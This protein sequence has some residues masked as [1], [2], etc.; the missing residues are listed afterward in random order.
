MDDNI[1]SSPPQ[2]LASSQENAISNSHLSSPMAPPS[3]TYGRKLRKPPPITP[4]RFNKFFTPRN[5]LTG[6]V[7]SRST[8]R[9]GRQL[10]D[11]TQRA[12]N[13]RNS[14]R[15]SSTQS[16]TLFVDVEEKENTRTP[17]T[18]SARKRRK[19][20]DPESSP[21]QPSPS[22]K[23]RPRSSSAVSVLE[24]DID[25]MSDDE[26]PNPSVEEEYPQPIR[27]LKSSGTNSRILQRSFGGRLGIDRGMRVDH[28][29]DWSSQVSD[30]YTCPEDNH[31]FTHPALPFCTTSCNT[32]SL[33][34]IGDEEGGVRLVETARDGLS[35]FGKAHVSFRPHSNAVMDL[36]F[37][38]D[39]ILLATA[40]GDQTAHVI[41]MSTQKPIYLM[42]GHVSSVK[43]VLFQPG[44]DSIIA[45]SSRDGAVHLWDL[46][47]SGVE[48]PIR[49]WYHGPC[50]TELAD[51]K[52]TYANPV[53]SIIGAH[54]YRPPTLPQNNSQLRDAVSK[55]ET[56]SRVGDVSITA[57]SFLPSSRSHLLLTASE[58]S[59]TVKLWD[60]RARC[61]RRGQPIALST[62]RQPESH[63][64]HRHFGINSLTLS[65]D[66]ARFYALSRD[67]TV[68]AYSTNHLILGHA[69]ELSSPTARRQR[70]GSEGKEGLGPIYGF[71]HPMLHATTFYVKASLRR[72]EADR[73]E[74]LAVG[75]SDG[76]AVVFPTDEAFL[77]SKN[78][79]SL[80][81]A[82]PTSPM[83]PLA[84]SQQSIPST[85]RPNPR[86]TQSSNLFSSR[87][88]DTIPI[89]EHGAPLVRGHAKEV[90]S[91]CWTHNGDLVTVGD[92]FVGRCWRE[93]Q[94]RARDLRVSGEAE[95]KRWGCGWADVEGEDVEDD[96]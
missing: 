53:N 9:S 93:N 60:I 78:R 32:N 17:D 21:M 76:C 10:R 26:L 85:S 91:V 15:G 56:S 2:V 88:V 77:N 50:N 29:L 46:R 65:S 70:Y 61:T 20:A 31:Q 59:T 11:I 79:K 33:V 72:V 57:L 45:T 51:H 80:L 87:L 16:K 37:S 74:L 43:Q 75:S 90:T 22:K 82:M 25:L 84:S 86:R 38:S 58:A 14:R 12:V 27:R 55:I 34:A 8:G 28:C 4:K 3:T 94:G 19:L 35:Q 71:R 49:E 42:A 95:G 24:P 5:S 41:D 23:A 64:K 36:A 13:R 68:Y 67:S 89:Y 52:V 40:S 48:G 81:D 18:G 47:C 6:M 7:S 30:F 73:P 69:P 44:N 92:D 39:D 96:M 63:S 66:G 1:P 62:T 83:T 54:T